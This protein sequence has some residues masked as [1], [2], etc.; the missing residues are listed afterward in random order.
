MR[1]LVDTN[2]LLRVVA[3]DDPQHRLVSE[4]IDSHLLTD[5]LFVAPQC[6]YELW[7]VITRPLSVNG[8]GLSVAEAFVAVDKLVDMLDLLEDPASLVKR[9][10][11]VCRLYDV[12]GRPAHD[13]RLVAFALEHQI[14]AIVTLNSQDFATY[15][16][17]QVICP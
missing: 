6:L 15:R 3:G 1:L 10:L 13:A 7:T 11:E 17:I 4:F 14:Q 16:D 8:F 5:D 9:W 2:I 12:K